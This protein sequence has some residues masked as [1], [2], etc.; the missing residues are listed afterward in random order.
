ML[1]S[2]QF[3]SSSVNGEGF[4]LLSNVVEDKCCHLVV[5]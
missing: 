4:T 5:A 3:V 1:R 2:A